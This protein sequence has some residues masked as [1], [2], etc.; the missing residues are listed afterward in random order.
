MASAAQR[1]DL[2]AQSTLLRC[3]ELALPVSNDDYMALL[4]YADDIGVDDYFWQEGGAC[5][6]SFIPAF[7]CTGV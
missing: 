3:P 2:H 4:D 5:E 6:E 7:D 1:G